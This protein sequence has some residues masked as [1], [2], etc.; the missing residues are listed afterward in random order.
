MRFRRRL[1]AWLQFPLYTQRKWGEQHRIP[2][3]SGDRQLTDK[4]NKPVTAAGKADGPHPVDVHVGSR[5]RLR[6]LML[7]MSQDTLG[8]ALGLTFQQIQKYEKGIN[9][10]GAS[11]VFKLAETLSVPIQYF[12][13]DYIDGDAAAL[14]MA[15]G[16]A[17][18]AFMELVSSPEGVQLCRYFAEISDPKVR[19]RV[20]DLVRTI[21][22]TET[23][24]LDPE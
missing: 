22:E 20:L 10:I 5:V 12:Y 21:A 17:G 13:D 15:E 14:G 9:R 3:R 19:K 2:V 23:N 16:D 24:G 11:R 8:V 4:N 7:G 18:A 1:Y 6:R